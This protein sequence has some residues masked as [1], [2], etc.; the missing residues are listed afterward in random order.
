MRRRRCP[1]SCTRRPISYSL[2]IKAILGHLCLGLFGI[3][4]CSSVAFCRTRDTSTAFGSSVATVG[5]GTLLLKIPVSRSLVGAERVSYI[6]FLNSGQF[7]RLVCTPFDLDVVVT[8]VSPE[9]RNVIE[10]D[11]TDGPGGPRLL[12]WIANTSGKFVVQVRSAHETALKGT[13]ELEAQEIR[14]ATSTDAGVIDAQNTYLEAEKLRR[15]GD[16]DSLQSSIAKYQRAA[17][18]WGQAQKPNDQAESLK[19]LGCALLS[20]GESRKAPEPLNQALF[21]ARSEHN[22]AAESSALH[23]LG[24]AYYSVA[25]NQKALDLF[26]QAL[27][28][29]LSAEFV[30]QRADTLNDL[31]VVY[32]DLGHAQT[33]LGYYSQ[34]LI[35]KRQIGNR[36]DEASILNNIG[37]VYDN[38]GDK[39]TGLKYYKAG[40]A[41]QRAMHNLRQLG[42]NLNNVGTLYHSMGD[43]KKALEYYSQ[44]LPLLEKTKD[45]QEEGRTLSNIAR[46]YAQ[47]GEYQQAL[48]YF[49]RALPV[50]ESVGGRRGLAYTF[51]YMG[52]TYLSLGDRDQARD[53]FQR[54]LTLSQEASAP[55]IEATTLLGMAR[56]EQ[57]LGNLPEAQ[58]QIENCLDIIEQLRGNVKNPELRRAYL[59]TVQPAYEFYINLLMAREKQ[60]PNQGYAARALEAAERG[61][62]RTL[63]D[64]LS[65]AQIDVRR[66]VDP[67]LIERER[68]L[69]R[70]IKEKSDEEFRLKGREHTVKQSADVH[71]QLESLVVEHDAVEGEIR[72]SSPRYA[73]LPQP[74][75]LGVSDIQVLLDPGTLLL[76]YSLGTN[77]SFVWAA[78]QTRFSSFV[79]PG[80]DEIEPAAKRLYACLARRKVAGT[81]NTTAEGDARAVGGAASCKP[82]IEQLS[83]RLLGPVSG[84]AEAKRLVIVADGVLQYIPF[85]VLSDTAPSNN[86]ARSGHVGG[87]LENHEIVNLPSASALLV[88]RH[89]NEGR[90]AATKLVA[91]LAD[92]VFD[93]ADPRVDG[94]GMVHASGVRVQQK[95][96]DSTSSPTLS[97]VRLSR[98]ASDVHLSTGIL[99]FGRLP[100]TREEAASIL[101]MAPGDSSLEALDFGA[102]R[103]TAT[104]PALAQYRIVHFATHGLL[105]SEHPEFSGLVFS[106]VNQSGRPLNGFLELE[107]IYN[108]RLNADLV[109]LSACE[110]GLGKDIK[111]E[112]L[113]G[114]TRGFMYAGAPRVVAS[115]WKVDDV[116]TA[117]LMKRF[118]RFMLQNRLAPAAALR[119]A[120]LK[121]STQ[122]R[123]ADPYYWAGFVIQ[124]EWR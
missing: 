96:G 124:G 62:A 15:A 10:L 80:R 25:E 18:L 68:N 21:L 19:Q 41:I 9:G 60:N 33:A 4:V 90:S 83:M 82:A 105:D 32:D 63:L 120:Q 78:T 51:S 1:A 43:Q 84:L 11:T 2:R 28:M 39:Q 44:A 115:L 100:F 52:D 56:L 113:V 45:R 67:Q 122:R 27:P 6:L 87:L 121:M 86:R 55:A 23:A 109:V 95:H 93:A 26:N 12:F 85:G 17:D 5:S 14:S 16:G 123:W 59:S 111:G 102:S 72:A 61:R 20:I 36:S 38:F 66:D 29:Q 34:A 46:S 74:Q 48:K 53:Y 3:F 110:T 106:L 104:D 117:E 92:P 77:R 42:I 81:G 58:V 103:A 116:A 119:E 7:V 13:Y 31:A 8:I 49:N 94:R 65:E 99:R 70:L 57:S 24:Q 75:P 40:V 97:T 73:A 114:L 30:P 69:Q 22:S 118:Y 112:G 50:R 89:V 37:I 107:D 98:S 54:A 35:L 88:I 101:A 47:L 79:L 64:I 76:E 71:R 91:V 108:L